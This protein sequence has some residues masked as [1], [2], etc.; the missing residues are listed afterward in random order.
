MD[1]RMFEGL[2]RL[3]A[4][5]IWWAVIGIISTMISVPVLIYFIVKYAMH[6]VVYL[7]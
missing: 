3:A 6:H 1:G 4:F 7:P 5:L 2:D